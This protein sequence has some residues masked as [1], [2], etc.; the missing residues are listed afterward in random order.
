MIVDKRFQNNVLL[1]LRGLIGKRFN[2][3]KC[4]PFRFSNMVYKKIGFQIE[5]NAYLLKNEISPQ[6]Y[7]G[8]FEDICDFEFIHVQEQDICSELAGVTQII[9]PV[10]AAISQISIL[11]ESRLMYEKGTLI[12]INGSLRKKTML[13]FTLLTTHLDLTFSS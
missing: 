4:D 6:P 9:M 12:D 7:F 5:G 11:N 13:F 10:N 8:A 2:S 1:M 3:Y